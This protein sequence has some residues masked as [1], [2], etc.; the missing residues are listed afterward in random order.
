LLHCLLIKLKPYPLYV[1]AI[2]LTEEEDVL[3]WIPG[4][5]PNSAVVHQRLYQIEYVETPVASQLSSSL[6]AQKDNI[7]SK[8][9]ACGST[10]GACPVL[11]YSEP[12][13]HLTRT[14]Q[15]V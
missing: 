13:E 14:Y 2:V 4:Q 10:V 9:T 15:A 8:A 6:L 5:I 11:A 1:F 3:S 12:S 7:V